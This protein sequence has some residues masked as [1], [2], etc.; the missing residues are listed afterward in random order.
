MNLKFDETTKANAGRI[1]GLDKCLGETSA[2]IRAELRAEAERLRASLD[3]EVARLDEELDTAH[4]KHDITKA[5]LNFCQ[6]RVTEQREW[7]QR[8]FA[9]RESATETV[10]TEACEG[11]AAL[12]R[13]LHALKDDEV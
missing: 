11:L 6:S 13:M 2:R 4:K 9:E 8:L 12:N 1:A 3:Q 5:E 10:Q 7:A